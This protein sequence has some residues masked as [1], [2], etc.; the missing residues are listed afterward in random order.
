MQTLIRASVWV[1]LVGL[2]CPAAAD[3]SAVRQDGQVTVV[4]DHFRIT[5]NSARGGEITDIRLFDGSQWNRLLGGDGQTCP[6]VDLNDQSGRYCLAND[7]N[8]TVEQFE[9]ADGV[10]RFQTVGKL[11]DGDGAPSPWTVK[12]SYEVH[13]EGAL[14][15]DVEYALDEGS[16]ARVASSMSFQVDRSVAKAA[17]YRQ[18]FRTFCDPKSL[19]F[20][21]ARV[22][23]GVNPQR[24]YTNE[25]EAIVERR[26]PMGGATAV[27]GKDGRFLWTLADGTS[28][29]HAP[30]RYRN[31]F[32]MGLGSGVTGTGK[33]M[34]K[35]VAQ[36]EC[37]WVYMGEDIPRHYPTNDEIDAMA[38]N[39]ATMLHLH[40]WLQT[41][42]HANG[43][44]HADYVPLDE[45]ELRRVIA[46][47]HKKGLRVNLYMR[48]IERYGLDQKFFQK[49][50][51]RDW[52]GIYVD[53]HGPHCAA[54]HERTWQVEPALG[55]EHFSKDG[56][57][58]AAREYFLFAKRL[59]QV[60]GPHGYLIGHQGSLNSGVIA[61]LGFDAYL[62]G[63]TP[64]DHPMFSSRDEAV[65]AGMMGGG[66]CMPYPLSPRYRTP[67]AVAKMAAW[68]LYPTLRLGT[69]RGHATKAKNPDDPNDPAHQYLSPYW[70][71][72][73]TI[74]ADRATVFNLP[75]VN[76]IAATCSSPDFSCVVYREDCE[77]G[78]TADDVY[79]VVVANLGAKPDRSGIALVPSVLGMSGEYEIARIDSQTGAATPQGATTRQITTSVLPPWG[80]EGY[81]LSRKD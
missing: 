22:A 14:F 20:P 46:H 38:A 77:T 75:S 74:D 2:T 79:L 26:T 53:W 67:E 24:S 59:R 41:I 10:A 29:V 1:V 62:P 81:R 7:K 65:F 49:Y 48:G 25:I 12:L 44:P 45:N 3:F 63:E 47:A 72:L 19:A 57:R 6:N 51:K 58:V 30:F 43:H 61:N 31:R 17:R 60:V 54:L 28:E 73:A 35:L 64:S 69:V 15:I 66:L 23:F 40:R 34:T 42:P 39:G 5:A 37:M 52:D 4:G 11:C 80:I 32:S 68:G 55:D 21:S 78:S 50:L 33:P 36:R 27:E 8:A 18:A 16:S 56:T 71:I 13:A 76:R 9:V 70:R